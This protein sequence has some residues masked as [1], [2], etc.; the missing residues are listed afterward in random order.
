MT[1]CVAFGKMPSQNNKLT[2][3]NSPYIFNNAST[4]ILF[5]VF[6]VDNALC[7]IFHFVFAELNFIM[8][9]DIQYIYSSIK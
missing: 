8:Y 6:T 9:A 5:N 3:L 7:T 2:L 1:S 4:A